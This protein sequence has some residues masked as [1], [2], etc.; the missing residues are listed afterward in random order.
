MKLIKILDNFEFYVEKNK[1]FQI[2][3][4]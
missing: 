4:F 1:N 3:K 2:F